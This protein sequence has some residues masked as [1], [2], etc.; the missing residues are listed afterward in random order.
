MCPIRYS[1]R[2]F[3]KVGDCLFILTPNSCAF[4]DKLG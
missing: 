3:T 2:H 4:I 1:D